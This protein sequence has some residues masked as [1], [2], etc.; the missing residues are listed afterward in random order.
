MEGSHLE[1]SWFYLYKSMESAC[2]EILVS[3]RDRTNI[4]LI[5][6]FV[7]SLYIPYGESLIDEH[8]EVAATPS[9]LTCFLDKQVSNRITSLRGQGGYDKEMEMWFSIG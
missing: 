1:A 8:G 2:I 9:L 7:S 3:S 5:P 6:T 4:F